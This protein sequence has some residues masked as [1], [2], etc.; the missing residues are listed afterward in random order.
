LLPFAKITPLSAIALGSIWL[1]GALP[2]WAASP[3][4]WLDGPALQKRLREPIGPAGISASGLPLRQRLA[5]LSRAKEVA[6]LLDRRVDPDQKLSVSIGN[7]PLEEALVEIASNRAIGVCLLGPVVYFGP[8]GVTS[9][10][11]TVA[12][13]R[14][15]EVDKLRPA[16]SSKFLARRRLA[17]DD[18]ATPRELLAQV[19]EPSGVKIVG[20]EQVPHDLWAAADLPP[21]SLI[22]RLSLIAGQFGLTFQVGPDGKTVTLVPVPDEV[23][24]VR[25]YPGGPDPEG[26]AGKW[27]ELVPDS[28]IKVVGQ[29]VFVKGL[30]EDHERL[31]SPERPTKPK[32]ADPTPVDEIQIDYMPIKNQPLRLVLKF[33]GDKL[34]LD[35][36][37]DEEAIRGAGISLDQLISLEV[38]KATVDQLFTKMLKPAGLT[39]RRR[40]RVIQIGPARP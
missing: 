22:E 23:A 2:V 30:L 28:Q 38:K 19:A 21:L 32:K 17:W 14:R 4:K 31:T 37:V 12:E 10:M 9:R 26:L 13:L 33:L 7:R 16:S 6:I 15:E 40:G 29:R 34:A 27:A 39:F 18:F 36:Q 8:I 25:S 1:M 11:R 20:L 5:E 24:L 35:V 3:P